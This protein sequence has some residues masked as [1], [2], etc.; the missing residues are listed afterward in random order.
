MEKLV[1]YK[2]CKECIATKE[3]REYGCCC[4]FKKYRAKSAPLVTDKEHILLLENYD[5]VH[6]NHFVM[7]ALNGWQIIPNLDKDWLW[8]PFLNR[9][10]WKCRV[11]KFRPF[12]CKL[13]PGSFVRDN[14]NILFGLNKECPGVNSQHVD[15]SAIKESAQDFLK[16]FRNNFGQDSLVL[17]IE[18]I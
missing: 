15:V 2:T 6:A 14:G 3:Q 8:C 11:Y 12:D 18:S 16:I 7:I 5:F 17:A 1:S 9:V 10:E 4:R 13:F